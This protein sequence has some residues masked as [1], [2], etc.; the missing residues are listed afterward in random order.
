MNIEKNIRDDHQAELTVEIDPEQMEAAKRKAAR[1]LAQRGKIPGFRP[2]KAPY[3]MIRR[4]YGDEAI[5][6]AA[7]DLLVDDLYPEILK[8]AEVDPAA[9]GSLE[10]V[11]S[12]DPPKFVFRVPL[13][14]TVDLG[15]YLSIR[16]PYEWTPPGEKEL[17]EALDNLRQMYASTKTVEREMQEGD[18]ALISVVGEKQGATEGEDQSELSRENTAVVVRPEDKQSDDEWPFKGFARGLIGMKPGESKTVTHEYPED[19]EDAA[20]K[21]ATVVFNATVKSVRAVTLPELNDE[22]A[23]TVSEQYETLDQLKDFMRADLEAHARAEYDDEYFNKV[24]EQIREGAAIK[25]PPQV[26]DHEGEHVLGELSQRLAS[27]GMDLE[28][29]FK[30]RNTTREKFMEDEVKPAAANRLARGLILDEIARIHKVN[31]DEAA[32]TEEFHQTLNELAYQGAV[33]FERLNKSGK[34]NQA[35]FSSAVATQSANRLITR[36]T[37]EKIKSIALGEWKPEDDEPKAAEA[38]TGPGEAAPASEVR[39]ETVQASGEESD[40]ETSTNP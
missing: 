28:T 6:E 36:R 26:L 5:V 22:F 17:D 18:Y 25:Y 11:E 38:E 39:E 12:F 9:P 40:A 37:L 29:Y 8:Q 7:I 23:K 13:A 4:H 16:V 10:K 1:R 27:Q 31:F 2:G 35:R 15:D 33:D 30:V 21:G 14:P 19:E 34:E 24:L 20:L 32:L 3:D